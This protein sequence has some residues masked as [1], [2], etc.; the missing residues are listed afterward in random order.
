MIANLR[1]FT[2]ILVIVI[3]FFLIAFSFV[4]YNN[5]VNNNQKESSLIV[6]SVED[7][8]KQIFNFLSFITKIDWLNLEKKDLATVD[9]FEYAKKDLVDFKIINHTSLIKN[10][11]SLM[12]WRGM[13]IDYW[14]EN[15]NWFSKEIK[16]FKDK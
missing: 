4:K 1:L 7:G 2:L 10:S 5:V 8:E 11:F 16:K 14:Q 15:L 6:S 12:N 13:W 3:L 9:E